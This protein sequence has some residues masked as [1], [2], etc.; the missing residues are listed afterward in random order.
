MSDDEFEDILDEVHRLYTLIG[1]DPEAQREY[2][3]A[4]ARVNNTGG[5]EQRAQLQ[6]LIDALNYQRE[7]DEADA[8]EDPEE[9]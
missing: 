4:V 7:E 8:E 6:D 9:P 1:R 2:D 3:R 5:E